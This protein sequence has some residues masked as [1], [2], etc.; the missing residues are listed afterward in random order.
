[1]VD[2]QGYLTASVRGTEL[3][4]HILWT[5]KSIIHL[6]PKINTNIALVRTSDI[7]EIPANPVPKHTLSIMV[8]YGICSLGQ[9]PLY[10]VPKG[11]NVTPVLYQKDI[12]PIYINALKILNYF[13]FEKSS[14]STG[15]GACALSKVKYPKTR[16]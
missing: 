5:D 12:L 14:I 1:M 11:S 6:H 9:T 10:I 3:R 13:L 7:S 4:T 15:Y 2:N 16:S 8:S